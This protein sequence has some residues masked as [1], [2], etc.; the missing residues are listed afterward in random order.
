MF[1]LRADI[2]NLVINGY[3]TPVDGDSLA[4][5]VMPETQYIANVS[6][7]KMQG[8]KNVCHIKTMKGGYENFYYV[9]KPVNYQ[10]LSR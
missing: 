1:I 5:R 7:E 4:V 3:E 10:V 2:A 6:L 9:G 8:D